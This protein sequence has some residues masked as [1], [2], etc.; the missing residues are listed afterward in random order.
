MRIFAA[1]WVMLL[2][3]RSVSEHR[4]WPIPLIDRFVL[5][6]QYAVDLFFV[7]SGFIL[8]HVYFAQFAGGMTRPKFQSFIGYRFARLYPVHIV[9]FA[10]MVV[11]FFGQSILTGSSTAQDSGRYSV[12][13][14]LSTLTMTHAWWGSG[15]TTTPNVPAW[16]I[17]AEW[18]AY[19]LFPLLCLAIIRLRRF[20][21]LVF[22]LLGAGLALLWHLTDDN[23]P[24]R[25]MAGFL[26]GMATY[27]V[28]RH[29]QR[30]AKLPM[31]G[32]VVLALVVVWAVLGNAHLEIGILLFAGL[33]LVLSSER[34]WLCRFFALRWMVYLG[35]VSYAVYMIHWVVRVV[36]RAA[37]E[38]A[39]VLDTIPAGL[40][41]ATYIVL[42][43]GAAILLY[44][45]VERPWR[46]RLRRLLAPRP[47]AARTDGEVRQ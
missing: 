24:I 28:S 45:L 47:K 7:L 42:T 37:A 25:V 32:T 18:L 40:L 43:F 34:D 33:I 13:T 29:A 1:V 3:F 5:S 39:G 26:V 22:T 19:L 4:T 20:A 17:S 10:I 21:P 30:L 2:H 27:Q 41:V 38:R 35:E 12:G 46:R 14:F 23:V 31:L 44:H 15:T 8:C 36:V 11:L 6:G 16:S 9:T